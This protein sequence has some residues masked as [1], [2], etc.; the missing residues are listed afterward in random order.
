[1]NMYEA[2]GCD[3]NDDWNEIKINYGL[4]LVDV[5]VSVQVGP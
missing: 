3:L 4:K 2:G 1:M 5:A